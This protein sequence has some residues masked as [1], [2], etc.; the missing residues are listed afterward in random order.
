MSIPSQLPPVALAVR[1]GALQILP[2]QTLEALVLGTALNGT[3]QVQIGQ[4]T[5]SLSLPLPLPA[6]ATLTLQAQ[7]TGTQQKLVLLQS[8]VPAG[9]TAKTPPTSGATPP[10]LPTTPG[11]SSAAAPVIL[12]VRS[13][14][15]Q[16][17][18]LPPGTLVD[19]RVLGPAPGGA[20]Q[21]QV[22]RQTLDV[23]LP[24]PMPPGAALPLQVQGNDG[25][26]KLV[27]L[28]SPPVSTAPAAAASGQAVAV[29]APS[30]SGVQPSPSATGPV[31]AAALP[32]PTQAG[33]TPVPPPNAPQAALTQM[34][35]AAVQ[36]QD[37]MAGLT[38]LLTSV[39]G[40][41]ALP[42]PVL[43][44]AQQL[45]SASVPLTGPAPDGAALQRAI[46]ASGIFQEAGLAQGTPL[47]AKGDVKTLL[48]TLRGALVSWLGPSPTVT[49]PSNPLP[50]P[51][52]GAV[53][54]AR[55][56]NAG[57]IVIPEIPSEAGKVMLERTE[58]AL[59]R[60][61]LHQHASLPDTGAAVTKAD[62]S[63]DLPVLIGGY[64]SVM[65]LH[66]HRDE[67]GP[68]QAVSERGW[69]IRFAMDVPKLG[70]VGAQ[71][72]LRGGT[73]SVRLWASDPAT[74]RTI[75]MAV[76]EL[77]Q[78]LAAAGLHPGMVIVR[79]DEAVQAPAAGHFVDAST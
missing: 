17:L 39:V 38:T 44:A 57:P 26:Q 32:V 15:V 18:A 7:G 54:R 24:T 6:G 77:S 35:Q 23:V 69:H 5:L 60:L 16:A 66:I 53:P 72:G 20:T 68:E 65:Q 30:S 76:P 55:P 13:E 4:Q 61:R 51:V 48:L 40:K 56:P 62:W 1:P 67:A 42:Q 9:T 50:P 29:A 14:T 33:A 12:P 45:L 43:Q 34:V 8:L 71:V 79:A 52:R 22:G 11:T 36:R 37:S 59:A 70:E 3:T 49:A 73:T 28:Q 75:E 27:L 46:A 64:Q 74:A 25:Q 2:G 19:A 41:V 10:A 78:A 63:M 31:P 21:I 47:L 58:G